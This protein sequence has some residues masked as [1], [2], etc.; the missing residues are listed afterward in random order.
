MISWTWKDIKFPWTEKNSIFYLPNVIL[1]LRVFR[2]RLKV[3]YYY[4]RY[5]LLH[6]KT[7]CWRPE[8]SQESVQAIEAIYEM[9]MLDINTDFW[10]MGRTQTARSTTSAERLVK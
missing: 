9:H 10:A 5:Q 6:L 1:M 2:R 7:P 3:E 4:K 8:S